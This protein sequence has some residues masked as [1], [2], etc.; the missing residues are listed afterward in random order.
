MAEAIAV[1]SGG[2][3]EFWKSHIHRYEDSGLSGVEY[4]RTEG[5]SYSRFHYWKQKVNNSLFSPSGP[6]KLVQVPL[7]LG[8]NFPGPIEAGQSIPCCGSVLRIWMGAYCLEV[9]G[10]FS[11]ALLSCVLE[12]LGRL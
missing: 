1:E 4:C 3:F 6:L 10:D 5:I 9:P 11:P 12:T 2:M 8:A 7:D